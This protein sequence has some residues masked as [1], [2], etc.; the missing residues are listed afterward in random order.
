MIYKWNIL[1]KEF[2][3]EI[4]IRLKVNST[5]EINRWYGFHKKGIYTE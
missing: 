3:K 1:K 5:D 4:M 2:A